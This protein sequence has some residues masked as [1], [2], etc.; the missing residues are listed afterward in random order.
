MSTEQAAG[1]PDTY[2]ESKALR[3]D[4]DNEKNMDKLDEKYNANFN[5][6][7]IHVEDIQYLCF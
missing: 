4:D 1:Q 5:D 2:I 6:H 3:H 7:Q